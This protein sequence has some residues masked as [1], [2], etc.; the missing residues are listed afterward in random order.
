MLLNEVELSRDETLKGLPVSG[1]FLPVLL[2]KA[3]EQVSR[4]GV[5]GGI[6]SLSIANSRSLWKCFVK[7]VI[8]AIPPFNLVVNPFR[9]EAHMSGLLGL[10]VWKQKAITDA[11]DTKFT[12]TTKSW[13]Q[14][15]HRAMVVSCAALTAK[16]WS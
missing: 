14:K 12:R 16:S 2:A 3:E 15:N 10:F 7:G 8:K 6:S 13:A 9:R 1:V 4:V 5:V 11:P